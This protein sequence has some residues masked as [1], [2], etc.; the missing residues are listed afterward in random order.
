MLNLRRRLRKLAK[1]QSVTATES[2]QTQYLQMRLE[3]ARQRCKLPTPSPERLAE[4]RGMTVIQ[5]LKSARQPA[6]SA[7]ITSLKPDGA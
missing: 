4:L 2:E 1:Q 3:N 5:I 6:A 7:R